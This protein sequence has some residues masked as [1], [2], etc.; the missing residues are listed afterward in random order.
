MYS[1]AAEALSI[2][3]YA[4]VSARETERDATSWTE[5]VITPAQFFT[6]AT[7]TALAWSGERKL[8]LAVLRDAVE[9]FF[10]YRNDPTT[11]GR[12]LFRE[13]HDWFWSMDRPWLCS[14]DNICNHLHLDADYIRRGLKQYYDPAAVSAAPPPG[15]R[16]RTRR[17]GAHLTIV[18]GGV[19]GQGEARTCPPNPEQGA[20]QALSDK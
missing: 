10:R 2:E 19:A 13:T 14:F 11:R 16:H 15:R 17:A 6:T 12:R 5:E 3:P 8:L 4:V 20:E 7:D 18:S 9:S 1:A